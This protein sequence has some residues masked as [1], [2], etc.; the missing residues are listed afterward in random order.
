MCFEGLSRSPA[1]FFE[2]FQEVYGDI[3][4]ER[5]KGFLKRLL[6]LMLHNKMERFQ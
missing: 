4:K 2:R 1:V 5:A 3:G 6:K